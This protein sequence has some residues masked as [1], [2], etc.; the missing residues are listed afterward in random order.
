MGARV[1]MRARGG[2]TAV[3]S[4]LTSSSDLLP[5]PLTCLTNRARERK[6]RGAP[7][8]RSQRAQEWDVSGAFSPGEGH[9][10]ARNFIERPFSPGGKRETLPSSSVVQLWSEKWPVS[11]NSRLFQNSYLLSLNVL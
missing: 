2:E 7:E 5:K 6:G 3:N 10:R 4:L 8:G 9:A 1:R 11:H